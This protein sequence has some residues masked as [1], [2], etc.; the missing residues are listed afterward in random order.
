MAT[1]S[2]VAEL[3]KKEHKNW[4]M[5]G[6]AL[7]ITKNG[8]TQLIQGK[9]EAWYQSLISSPPLQSLPPCTCVRHSL[10]CATCT[11]WKKEL[12]RLHK[13]ARPK[14]CWDNS[15]RQQWGSLTGA[16]EIAK[17]FMP[18]LGTRKRDITDANTTDIGGLLNMLE[19]CPFIHPPV[20]RAVLSSVRD[21]GRN[22]WAHSP[23][24]ELQDADVKTIF[25]YLNSL[26]NDPVFHS[27]KAAQESS[28]NL[29][30][31]FHH[32]LLTVRES[33]V[34]ALH[35]LRQSLVADLIK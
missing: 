18:T 11:T 20:N 17:I 33:E 7:N 27:D 4:V 29:Q 16:W 2:W 25:G 13:S 32:G 6:C 1:A 34:E 5:A 8:I 23:K 9:M 24:Q 19:W 10:K 28:I 15:D 35:L 30:D 22:H 31:L 14:I 26:L 3:D 21:E 12:E